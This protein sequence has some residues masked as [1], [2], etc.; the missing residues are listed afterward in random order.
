M[1]NGNKLKIILALISLVLCITTVQ[2]TYA[3]YISSTEAGANMTIARWRIL[4]NSED[5]HTGTALQNTIVPI[6]GYRDI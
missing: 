4:V 1:L 3:K 5:I 6:S 2:Q